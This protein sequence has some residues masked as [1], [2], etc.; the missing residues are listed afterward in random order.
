MLD[1]F[2]IVTDPVGNSVGL[3]AIFAVLLAAAAVILFLRV[4]QPVESPDL[5]VVP[6][7]AARRL[8]RA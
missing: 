4:W 5:A 2:R 6:A 1:Q 8:R 7:R 3:S